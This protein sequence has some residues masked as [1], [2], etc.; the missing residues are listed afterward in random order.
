MI[1]QL[2]NSTS[3]INAGFE[4]IPLQVDKNIS[5]LI[6]NLEDSS[7]NINAEAEKIPAQIEKNISALLKQLEYS[8]NS[9]SSEFEKIP[10]QLGK[11]NEQ[12]KMTI[13][14]VNGRLEEMQKGFLH[15]AQSKKIVF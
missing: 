14:L 2:E 5:N 12:Y 6:I 13:D 1:S 15:F 11:S 8:A 9:I 4:K 7:A 10:I 3:N